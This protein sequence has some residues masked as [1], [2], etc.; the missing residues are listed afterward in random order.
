MLSQKQVEEND[1]IV[2]WLIDLSPNERSYLFYL[3]RLHAEHH[4]PEP[5]YP[6][7]IK[8]D[9]FSFKRDETA[10]LQEHDS[11]FNYL[12]KV[13]IPIYNKIKKMKL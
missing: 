9:W 13:G 4:R 8:Y 5:P 3:T 12:L 6:V 2:S 1:K 7:A 11:K 10:I